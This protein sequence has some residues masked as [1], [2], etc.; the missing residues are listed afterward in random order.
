MIEVLLVRLKGVFLSER[1]EE[2]RIFCWSSR[3]GDLCI[4]VYLCQGSK[5][6]NVK[7]LSSNAVVALL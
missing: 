2:M 4:R 1:A 3:A 7:R 6:E 5:L